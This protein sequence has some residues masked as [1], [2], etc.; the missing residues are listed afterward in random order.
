MGDQDIKDLA[1]L[2]ID[3]AQIAILTNELA[4]IANTEGYFLWLN[5]RWEE[6]LGWEEAELKRQ[7]FLSFV[8]PDDRPATLVEVGRLAEGASTVNFTNRYRCQDGGWVHLAWNTVP[9]HNNLLIAVARDVTNIKNR[10]KEK[11]NRSRL[12][13]LAESLS[14]VG[15]WR[16]DIG[17]EEIFWSDEV[18]RIHGHDP[19]TY[20]PTLA[21]GLKFYHPDDRQAVEQ[22]IQASV[23]QQAPFEFE[24][25]IIRADG[26]TRQVVSKGRVEVDERG[27]TTA[28]FGVFQDITD[29]RARERSLIE[30]NERLSAKV[31]EITI[32]NKELRQLSELAD[33]LQSS[34]TESEISDVLYQTLPGYFDTLSGAVYLIQGSRR[35][36][37]KIVEWGLLRQKD[38]IQ[39]SDCWSLRRGSPHMLGTQRGMQ[40]K[41]HL[42]R[43]L[44]GAHCSPMI[45]QGENIGILVLSGSAL[46]H[47]TTLKRFSRFIDAISTHVAM[48][49]ANV[50]LRAQLHE[51]STRD[52]LTR[53]YNR[54]YLEAAF[55]REIARTRRHD[56]PLSLVLLDL[57]HFKQFNDDYGHLIADNLL[58]HWGSILWQS[59]RGED[60]A[61]RWGGEEFVLLLSNT[62]EEAAERLVERLQIA[63]LKIAL[64][65]DHGPCRPVTLSAGITSTQ[66]E[67]T[68]LDELMSFADQALYHAKKSGR[69]RAARAS[70]CGQAHSVRLLTPPPLKQSEGS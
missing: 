25:R 7:P 35:T 45:A 30:L 21:D 3:P 34:E 53:L 10:E 40:C 58:K 54:R 4:C 49:V 46:E 56:Q 64:H 57:D 16:V 1:Q 19:Q 28:I 13:A 63:L 29:L 9:T 52:P 36:A 2:V 68:M 20:K 38:V 51:H 22:A 62:S 48:S 67:E 11:D 8:H 23:E 50:R 15:H 39:I 18:Y 17:A 37:I 42:E 6:V 69:N 44:G 70:K 43:P 31:M 47:A 24:R 59:V 61:A 41:H 14:Q 60:V 65:S 66:G 12:L 27:M 5:P 55:E 33:L 26:E 32:R